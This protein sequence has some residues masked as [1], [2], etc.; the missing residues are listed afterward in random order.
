MESEVEKVQKM[1][2][3]VYGS[4]SLCGVEFALSVKSIQEVINEPEDYIPMPLAPNYLLGLFSLRGMVIPVVDLGKIFDLK[5]VDNGENIDRKI[6]IIEHGELCVGLLFDGTGEVFNGHEE[7]KSQ[8]NSKSDCPRESVV[9]GVF[10]LDEGRRIIQIL[11]PHEILNLEKVPQ[12]KDSANA[13]LRR[14]KAGK[15]MQCISFYVGE[16]LCA[17]GIDG[18]QEIVEIKEMK[19]TTLASENCIGAVDLRG[20]TVPIIDFSNLLG[21]GKV[22]NLNDEI[23][24]INK[25]VV[26]KIE[27]EYFGLLVKSIESIISYYKEDLIKFPVLGDKKKEMFDGCISIQDSKETIL[28]NHEKILTN[29]E[30]NEITRGHSV[31]YKEKADDLRLI[32]EAASSKRSYITFS[33]NNNYA[34]EIS[35]VREV[36][37][38]P[39]ELI[40][41]PN[42]SKFFRGMINLRGDLVA[43]IDPR[44]LYG[45][46]EK[47]EGCGQKILIFHA[48]ETT[49][50]L[51][52][53]SVNSI[54]SFSQNDKV[55]LP[56]LLYKN[57]G[58]TMS[59]DVKEAVQ[60]EMNEDSKETLLIL[61]LLALSSRI[62]I[63]SAA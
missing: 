42:L 34:L 48:E 28:L 3:D 44:A 41:P 8:F 57:D 50:G 39:S 19:N 43:V 45:M 27:D 14:K 46:G 51:I 60:V 56:K 25:V 16:A 11:D 24:N 29:T 5:S 49:Y 7:E 17:I 2:R 33:I 35:E 30:V 9:Q 12:S 62:G 15:K 26:M 31:L 54:V 40:Q 6:A 55:K 20:N 47:S 22:S 59:E 4:F 38:Y 18:I 32:K 13:S 58:G 23:K 63:S 37:D 1:E 10:K 61:N 21:Y 53:D 36:I 52:V